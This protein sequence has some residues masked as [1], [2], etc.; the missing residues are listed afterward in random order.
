MEEHV[1]KLLELLRYVDYIK[2][3]QVKIQCFLGSL[4]Q[5]FRDRINFVN[6]PILDESIRMEMHC[7]EKIKGKSQVHPTW[8]GKPNIRFD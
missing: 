1:H 5:N 4:P 8:K 7:Y 6:P 2:D 3:E